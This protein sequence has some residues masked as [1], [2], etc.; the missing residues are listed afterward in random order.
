M[1]ECDDKYFPGTYERVIQF[2]YTLGLAE[3]ELVTV[4]T[5]SGGGLGKH[6]Y[7]QCPELEKPRGSTKLLP[8]EL[9][10]GEIRYG[11]MAYVAAPPSVLFPGNDEHGIVG[12]YEKINGDFATLPII[13]REMLQLLSPYQQLGY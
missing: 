7:L 9:G 12:V 2:L 13:T 10:A 6:I 11:F 3:K 1:L 5:P 4:K 8:P